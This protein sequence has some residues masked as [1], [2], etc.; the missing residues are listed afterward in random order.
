MTEKARGGTA[1]LDLGAQTKSTGT[2]FYCLPTPLSSLIWNGTGGWGGGQM[3]TIS[4]RLLLYSFGNLC[5]NSILLPMAH[6]NH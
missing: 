6:W 5:E 4:S 2:H 3:A 1:G